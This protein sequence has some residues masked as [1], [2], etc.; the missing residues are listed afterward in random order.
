VPL[1]VWLEHT[2]SEGRAPGLVREMTEYFPPSRMAC[3][4]HALP[5]TP[6]TRGGI[7]VFGIAGGNPPAEEP[8]FPPTRHATVPLRRDGGQPGG[9]N[10]TYSVG[11][12]TAGRAPGNVWP[13]PVRPQA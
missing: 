2:W 11:P 9:E 8:G 4:S 6:S 3:R 12:S 7:S 5:L 1:S 10:H 13:A